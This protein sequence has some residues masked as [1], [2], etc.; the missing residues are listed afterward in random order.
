L[1]HFEDHFWSFFQIVFSLGLQNEISIFSFFFIG[2]HIVLASHLKKTK[3]K[4][5]SGCDAKTPTI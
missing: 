1:Q 3:K 5:S 2:F 4:V